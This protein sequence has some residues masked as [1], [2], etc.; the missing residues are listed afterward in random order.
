[1]LF[2]PFLIGE[3]SKLADKKHK[4]TLNLKWV[5]NCSVSLFYL[6][7]FSFSEAFHFAFFFA[8]GQCVRSHTSDEQSHLSVNALL[9]FKLLIYGSLVKH[10][11]HTDRPP[12]LPQHMT[13]I[14]TATID[15]LGKRRDWNSQT[16]V[17]H[18]K[19]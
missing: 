19:S 8:L 4:H 5:F 18:L 1:M 10:Y 12:L 14:Y 2:T 13:D 6:R 7:S 16:A 3:T 15:L 17:C 9:G 11:N